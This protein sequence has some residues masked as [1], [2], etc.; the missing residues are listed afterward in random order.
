MATTGSRSQGGKT[1]TKGSRK[2]KGRFS[3]RRGTIDKLSPEARRTVMEKLYQG[4]FASYPALAAEL[5]LLGIQVT[6]SALHRFGRQF[7][8]QAREFEISQVIGGGKAGT[9]RKRSGA[10]ENAKGT[11]G[12]GDLFAPAPTDEE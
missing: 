10:S 4:N 11:D 9:L 3:F 5:A 1:G 8:R 2:G 12:Q 7:L 6:K